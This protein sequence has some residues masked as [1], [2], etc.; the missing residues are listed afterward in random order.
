MFIHNITTT[1]EKGSLNDPLASWKASITS[2][3]LQNWKKMHMSGFPLSPLP[4]KDFQKLFQ[5]AVRTTA[6]SE[7]YRPNKVLRHFLGYLHID[8]LKPHRLP[9]NII[10]SMKG[11]KT[12]SLQNYRCNT[13]KKL[14]ALTL[15]VFHV[16]YTKHDIQD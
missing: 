3:N 15:R 1:V 11:N 2:S 4:L 14:P 9:Q 6:S 13:A 8:K 16:I 10:W 12:Y 5:L 7:N